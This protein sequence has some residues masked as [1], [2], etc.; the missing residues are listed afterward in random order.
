MQ[1]WR[2]FLWLEGNIDGGKGRHQQWCWMAL[3]AIAE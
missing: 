3:V 2:Q 1:P